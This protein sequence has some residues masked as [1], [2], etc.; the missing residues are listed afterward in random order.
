MLDKRGKN[1]NIQYPSRS[2]DQGITESRL[3]AL[4][5]T[6]KLARWWTSDTRGNGS[7]VG[8]IL[9]FWFGESCHKFEVVEL[10]PG[11]LV[12]WKADRKEGSGE[13]VGTEVVFSLSADKKQCYVH[14]SHLAGAAI[15]EFSLTPQQ[16]GRFLC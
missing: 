12:R 5:D 7:K 10:Q 1:G 9:E 13:W 6:K 3:Q 16:N 8:G 4:T 15:V 2:R 14:F 11:K